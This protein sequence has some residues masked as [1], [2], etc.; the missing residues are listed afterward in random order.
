MN[1]LGNNRSGGAKNERQTELQCGIKNYKKD[2][3]I[4]RERERSKCSKQRVRE[5]RHLVVNLLEDDHYHNRTT[6]LVNHFQF[7]SVEIY[8][9]HGR[10]G[11]SSALLSNT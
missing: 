1:Y 10:S 9:R 3:K 11:S 5:K 4:E 2:W 6:L 8:V 7:N